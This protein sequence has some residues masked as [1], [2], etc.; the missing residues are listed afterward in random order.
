MSDHIKFLQLS[1]ELAAE[2][3]KNG[4]QPF[5]SVIV[6]DGQIVATGVNH[7]ERNNDPTA[8]AELV[9]IREA[10]KA[11]KTAD[12]SGCIVYASGE[13]CPMCQAA[14]FMSGI[15]DTYYAY[16]NAD[17]APYGFSSDHAVTELNKAPADREN[18]TYIYVPES[19]IEPNVFVSWQ[20]NQP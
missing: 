13:P 7:I 16:S 3:V 2:N 14:M 6:K 15:R 9:A 11:L 18:S 5:G 10:G 8:H 4:G 1:I 19:Q 12:L 20:R 17:G